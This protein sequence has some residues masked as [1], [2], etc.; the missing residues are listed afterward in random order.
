MPALPD[1]PNMLKIEHLMSVGNDGSAMVRWFVAYTGTA[2]SDSV[3]NS[4]AGACAAAWATDLAPLAN[5]DVILNEITV[6]DL[7][8]PTSGRG[9]WSGSHAG[10]RSTTTLPGATAVLINMPIARRYRG[11]K[12]RSY[13]P[14]L[15]G[16]DLLTAQQWESSAVTAVEGGLE[17]YLTAVY[18]S[19]SGGTTV[20]TLSNVSYYSGFTAVVNPI[21]GRTK[22]VPKLR[23]GGPVVDA[24][25][26][27]V[28]NPKPASQRRRSLQRV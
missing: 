23:T 24:I 9:V 14:F 17:S 12:P 5:T 25:I 7:T 8:S 18:A 1:V 16:T 21:T 22:D 27:L 3:C 6:T 26:S 13:W 4:I 10:T 20:S 19:G 2:P 11:G 15:G 28:C